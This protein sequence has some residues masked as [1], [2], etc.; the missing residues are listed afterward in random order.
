VELTP[1]VQ[2]FLEEPNL[3]HVVTL[4]KDGSPH[5]TPVWVDHDG[6]HVVINTVEGHQKLVNL[7]R[8]PRIA[9][10]IVGRDNN[11]HTLQVRGRVVDIVGG[12]PALEHINKMAQKYSGDPTRQYPLREGEQRVIV[13]IDPRKVSF[14]GGGGGRGGGGRWR[15]ES[16]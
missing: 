12:A 3:A 11:F 16:S 1:E 15:S 5:V 9:V 8:D 10:S 13:K 4:M 7:R 6:T 2:T 14:R